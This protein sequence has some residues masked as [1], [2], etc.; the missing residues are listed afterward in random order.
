M[1]IARIVQTRHRVPL[2]TPVQAAWDAEPRDTLDIDLVWVESEDGHVGIGAGL[3]MPGFAGHEDL[4]LERDA[5]DLERHARVIESLSFH[6]G[7]CWPLDLALWDLAGQ[8][9]QQPVWRLLGAQTNRLRV[10][11]AP[12]DTRSPDN[13]VALA[14]HVAASGF[15]AMLLRLTDADWRADAARVEAVRA[16][17]DLVLV[18]DCAQG[19]PLP[20][21]TETVRGPEETVALMGAL[22]ALGVFWVEDPLHRADYKGLASLRQQAGVTV[23]GGAHA[24]ELHELRTLIVRDAIDVLRTDAASLGGITSLLPILH[25]GKARNLMFSPRTW[26]NSIAMMANAHLAAASGICPCLEYPFDPPALTP[27]SRDHLLTSPILP[28]PDGWLTLPD[29][30][31]LGLDLDHDAL[32]D[33]QVALE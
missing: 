1:R 6:Y 3:P 25:R 11:A 23:A 26:S 31:G 8:I 17:A 24:R 13:L 9:H 14:R 2:E 20:W 5:L 12:G 15:P 28:D 10:F 4:F 32:Q 21:A 33:T 18:A 19:A 16:N 29:T 27:V 7:P 22:D 30:P